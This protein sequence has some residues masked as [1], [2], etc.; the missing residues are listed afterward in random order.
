M[1]KAILFLLTTFVINSSYGQLYKVPLEKLNKY[2]ETFP[3]RL[4]N[5]IRKP[6]SAKTIK[7][8]FRKV[9][10]YS[11]AAVVVILVS[12]FVINLFRNQKPIDYLANSSEEDLLEYVSNHDYEFDQNSLA[13][14]MNEDEVS[15]LDIMDEMDDATTNILIE[16]NK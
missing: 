12:W 16:L 13:T 1:K 11:A 10:M 8:G 2:F 6:Q 7:T 4:M 5:R 3:D 9:W 15:S 14:V